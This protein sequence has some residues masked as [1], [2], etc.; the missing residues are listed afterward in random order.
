MATLN[1]QMVHHF[2]LARSLPRKLD[3]PTNLGVAKKQPPLTIACVV[4]RLSYAIL[5]K[6][7]ISLHVG[8]LLLASDHIP[9]K[10]P[11]REII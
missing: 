10:N 11:I 8:P 9:A 2:P 7:E 6:N 1:N 3:L 4:V 5:C